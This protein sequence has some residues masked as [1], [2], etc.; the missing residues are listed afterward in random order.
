MSWTNATIAGGNINNYSNAVSSDGQIMVQCDGSNFTYSYAI[1]YTTNYGATW[2]VVGVGV[3]APSY[4]F[5]AMCIA[6]S[7]NGNYVTTF[8]EYSVGDSYFSTIA[9]VYN[10]IYV[11]TTGP[12]ALFSSPSVYDSLVNISCIAMSSDGSLQ[13]AVDVDG[14]YYVT[15]DYWANVT[16]TTPG[17]GAS[18]FNCIAM[19]STGKYQTVGSSSS[20]FV[21]D[22]S[23][24]SF[25]NIYTTAS[26]IIGVAVSY[27]GQYQ[28]VVT[29]T[30]WK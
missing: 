11:S 14:L 25:T 2:S 24:A 23:G 4:T 20:I 29:N 5:M 6:I 30:R 15:T 22:T 16:T 26:N 7:S 21:S 28:T 18:T 12:A 17:F 27:S 9:G 8:V 1:I 3:P 19:S 13:V 10:K